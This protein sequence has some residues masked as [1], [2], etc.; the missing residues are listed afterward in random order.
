MGY[1]A[2]HGI[3]LQNQSIGPVNGNA[4]RIANNIIYNITNLSTNAGSYSQGIT[5]DITDK[6]V[7]IYNNTVYNVSNTGNTNYARGIH[8]G[9]AGSTINLVPVDF[10]VRA[11]LAIAARSDSVG[12]TY[13][14]VASTPPT[15][16]RIPS[17]V[18]MA[19]ERRP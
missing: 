10:V 19:I 14:L 4:Y 11:T 5:W 8:V 2:T 1:H 18:S 16:G 15:I 3:F 13:H 7:Y 9:R 6:T 12:K 17:P